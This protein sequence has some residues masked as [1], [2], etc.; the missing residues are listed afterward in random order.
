MEVQ[1][2]EKVSDN[3]VLKRSRKDLMQKN[4]VLLQKPQEDYVVYFLFG[5]ALVP[6][7][8]IEVYIFKQS[9]PNIIYRPFLNI[10]VDEIKKTIVQYNKYDTKVSIFAIPEDPKNP[11]CKPKSWKEIENHQFLIIEQ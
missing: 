1:K 7:V 10:H 5:I 4:V 6:N 8:E 11:N 3:I 9:P 2:K